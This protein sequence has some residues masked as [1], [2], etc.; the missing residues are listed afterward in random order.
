M[1]P[2]LVPPDAHACWAAPDGTW[3]PAPPL[4]QLWLAGAINRTV[5]ALPRLHPWRLGDAKGGSRLIQWTARAA[6]PSGADGPPDT[7]ALPPAGQTFAAL[8]VTARDPDLEAG[9]DDPPPGSL[10]AMLTNWSRATSPA[11]DASMSLVGAVV[12]G[13]GSGATDA[14]RGPAPRWVGAVTRLPGTWLPPLAILSRS[15]S[16][17]ADPGTSW[18]T[19]SW[20]FDDHLTVQVDDHRYASAVLAP[21]VMAILLDVVPRGAAVTLA[22]DAVHVWWPYRDDFADQPGRTADTVAATARLAEAIPTF[23]Y[24]EHPDHSDQVQQAM[25]EQVAAAR[26]YQAARRP[27][28]SPDP[29]MQ[30]IYDAA[31]AA[32][33]LPPAGG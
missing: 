31:R 9:E 1:S 11:A 17:V 8:S 5:S 26:A 7:G 28:Y 16:G 19:E 21:H 12:G 18:R 32:A 13:L 24:A 29:T 2:S 3:A 20:D 22:G 25:D 33:G 6:D 30:R 27:G 15:T 10:D 14:V 23:I 4:V